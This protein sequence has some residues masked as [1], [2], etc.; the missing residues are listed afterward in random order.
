MRVSPKPYIVDASVLIDLEHGGLIEE[1]FLLQHGW[2]TPDVVI[3]EVMEPLGSQLTGLGLNT[4]SLGPEGVLEV[5]GLRLTYKRV[6]ANDLFCLVLAKS[7]KGTLITGDQ[8]L[9]K[10]AESEGVRVKGTL[11]VLDELVENKIIPGELAAHALLRMIKS[12][13]RFP[14]EE[15][16]KRHNR[17]IGKT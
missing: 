15:V 11:W 16:T 8:P 4:L 1:F 10:A 3:M 12:G 13:G 5:E 7:Q 6:S 17:W 14:Q 9:R 2:T